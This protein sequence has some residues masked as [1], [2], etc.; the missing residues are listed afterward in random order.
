M[1]EASPTSSTE[2]SKIDVV[3][4][5]RQLLSMRA[6][7]SARGSERDLLQL[8]QVDAALGKMD[9]G[10]YGVCDSCSRAIPKYRLLA[11]PHVRYCVAC[12]GGTIGRSAPRSGRG[13]RPERRRPGYPVPP[14]FPPAVETPAPMA[15]N[16]PAA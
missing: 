15:K 3:R 7:L 12:S 13:L 16:G 14:A 8:K 9:R 10:S 5:R 4:V 6:E 1:A 11:T 2:L